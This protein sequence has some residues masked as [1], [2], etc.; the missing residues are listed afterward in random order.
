MVNLGVDVP[1]DRSFEATREHEAGLICL[2]A[3]LTT[4]MPEMWHTVAAL[5]SSDL[6][7]RV[8][9]M[10]GGTPVTDSFANEIAADAC[11]EDAGAAARTALE[12]L[13][14]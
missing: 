2:S 9:V 12:L 3:L 6:S 13:A 4:T 10:V 8:K 1:A 5:R 7:D 14:G 11:S